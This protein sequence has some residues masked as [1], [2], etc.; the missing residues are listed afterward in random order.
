MSATVLIPSQFKGT[1]LSSLVADVAATNLPKEIVFDF[2]QL[3]FVRPAGV[4]FLNNI[5]NW[6]REQG[7]VVN[8]ANNSGRSPA[9]RFLDDS[10]FFEKLC[11]AKVN[12][13]A[14]PRSTTRPLMEIAHE[15][16]HAWLENDLIP[17]LAKQLAV[18]KPSLYEVKAVVSELFNNIQDHTRYDIGCVFVQHF[19]NENQV[20]IA[21]SDWGEGIPKNVRKVDP[22]LSDPE[23][24]IRATEEGFTT[25]SR[26]GNFGYGL[27]QLLRGIV[28]RSGGT[29]TI[30]SGRGIVRFR[31][32]GSIV[33]SEVE[34]EVGFCPGTTIDINL[35][36]DALE[37][38][39]DEREDLEW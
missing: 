25:K 27:D 14:S 31:R 17:W 20:N 8:F 9:L 36:A 33:R 7:V 22:K 15:Q 24:I 39:A 2:S 37:I 18:P 38:V 12:P 5:V 4:V 6:L 34:P 10:L 13:N 19:P 32:E 21:L 23:A 29:V 30:Y 16:S 28:E 1:T 26:P 11:G 35:R 3:N